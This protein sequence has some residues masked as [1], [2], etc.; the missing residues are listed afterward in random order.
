MV[1]LCW[2][3]IIEFP[4]IERIQYHRTFFFTQLAWLVTM[5]PAGSLIIREAGGLVGDF[6]GGE[7]WLHGKQVVAANPKI[8]HA[9][10]QVIKPHL[11]HF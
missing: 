3:L 5:V 7:D 2:W 11:A 4:I 10:L 6:S 8:F 9:M 1:D